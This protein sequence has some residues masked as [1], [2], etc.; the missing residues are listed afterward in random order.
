MYA[1][2]LG[3]WLA[4]LGYLNVTERKQDG[5]LMFELWLLY[6][7]TSSL[8]VCVPLIASQYSYTRVELMKH[9][10][11]LKTIILEGNVT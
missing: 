3:C 9:P 2:C 4:S 7:T 11:A 10:V 1:L 6:V 8:V 5:S